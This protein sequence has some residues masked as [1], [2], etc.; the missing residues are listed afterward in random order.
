MYVHSQLLASL[1]QC[2][3]IF[4]A[5]TR[6]NAICAAQN[7]PQTIWINQ[8]SFLLLLFIH[9]I[10]LVKHKTVVASDILLYNNNGQ[11]HFEY[12]GGAFA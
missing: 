10:G 3:F 11:N 8:R 5:K 12:S 4:D 7:Q 2:L 9:P 6:L 1:V